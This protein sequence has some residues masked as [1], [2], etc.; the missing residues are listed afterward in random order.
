MTL[1]F[2][3]YGEPRKFQVIS[4]SKPVSYLKARAFEADML[5]AYVHVLARKDL[6][7]MV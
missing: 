2:L 7:R 5:R 3:R 6:F 4:F 1:K